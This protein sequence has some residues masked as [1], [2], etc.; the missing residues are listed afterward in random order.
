MKKF[1]VYY[2]K[3]TGK[4]SEQTGSRP[5]VIIQN[6]IGNS[7]APTTIVVPITT[8]LKKSLPTHLHIEETFVS[9]DIM[10]EQITVIDKS[11]LVNYLG[12][13][14]DKYHKQVNEKI[15][16]SLGLEE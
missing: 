3:L 12:E 5:C 14:N 8:K 13:L 4:G 6:N 2:V 11:R 16:I 7:F 10:F 9:G 1:D 15:K